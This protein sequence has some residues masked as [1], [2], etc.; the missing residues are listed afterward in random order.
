MISQLDRTIKFNEFD[1]MHLDKVIDLLTDINTIMLEDATNGDDYN[2]CRQIHIKDKKT[3]EI[4]AIRSEIEDIAMA[5]SNL[6]MYV[7]EHVNVETHVECKDVGKYPSN[8]DWG[9]YDL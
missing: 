8:N 9:T 4:I 1:R 5:L 6:Y 2:S 7:S 3:G